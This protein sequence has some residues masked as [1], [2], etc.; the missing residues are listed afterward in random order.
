MAIAANA[1]LKTNAKAGFDFEDYHRGEYTDIN[2]PCL[3]RQIKIEERYFKKFN[4]LSAASDLIL[5][6]IKKDNPQFN[7]DYKLLYNSFPLTQQVSNQ[8]IKLDNT[9]QLF[10]FSQTI[11]L[12][13]GLGIVF[14]ALQI[15]NDKNIH[16]TL[17]GN[18]DETFKK[19]FKNQLTN[20]IDN[21]HF[22]GIIQPDNLPNF[23]SK[24]DVGLAVELATPYNR[25][26]CLTNKIFTYLLA[27][28]AIIFSNTSAQKKFNEDY[29]VGI[30]FDGNNVQELVDCIRFYRNTCNLKIQKN[31]NFNLAKS[32]F[33]WEMECKKI[34]QIIK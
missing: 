7:G 4:Y 5:A 1:A 25:D 15:L 14:E 3:K 32:I 9:L 23:S 31:Y 10:W 12:N 30:S 16:L 28:N 18:C 21:V 2:N 33:N 22:V 6:A 8:K 17:A 34:L 29:K 24:F 27:G 20:I 19:Y 13:R 11:G 26:I